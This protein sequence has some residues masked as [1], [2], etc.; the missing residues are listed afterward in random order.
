MKALGGDQSLV[1][2]RREAKKVLLLS[3][4]TILMKCIGRPS[5][6]VSIFLFGSEAVAGVQCQ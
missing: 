5:M 6:A 4:L 3:I 2:R 1:V